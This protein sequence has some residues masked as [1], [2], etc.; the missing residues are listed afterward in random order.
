MKGSYLMLIRH[1]VLPVLTTLALGSAVP[2]LAADYPNRALTVVVPYPPGG[3]TDLVTREIMQQLSKRIAQPIVIENRS[4]ANSIIGTTAVAKAK[5]DGYTLLTALGAFSIN[6]A[7]HS[8]LPYSVTDFSPVSLV[9]RVNLVLAVG[10]EVPVKSFA[11]LVAY[12]KSGS[13]VTYDSS[14][15]GSALHLV[16]SRISQATEMNAMHVP[17]KGISHSLLDIVSGRIT[18]TINT[19]SALGPY[20]REGKL[21]PLVV[22]SASRSPQLP[23]VPTIAEA[24]YPD[25]ESYAWQGLMVPASTPLNVIDKLSREVAA[26]VQEPKIRKKLSEMGLDA[27]GSTP[28]EFGSFL[29]EDMKAAAAIVKK[30]GIKLN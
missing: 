17:Y 13:Q 11:Q 19:V 8:D 30:A 3:N 1:L 23:N 27:I 20:F 15:I 5:P 25:L 7:L 4:G 28:A 6:P 21:T 12:G 2:V 9:G 10:N 18:F 22:L 29:A 24:G 16:G 26:V 14:G